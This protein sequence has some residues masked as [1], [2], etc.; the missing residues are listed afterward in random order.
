MKTAVFC[1][2]RGYNNPAL[3]SRLI[4]RNE[5]IYHF[6]KHES[7]DMV[8]FHEGNV[9]IEHQ[10]M[11]ESST[12]LTFKW[13]QIPWEFPRIPLPVET[14]STF[15]DGRCYPGYHLMCQFHTCDVWDY[16][17]DYDIV[18]RVDE[19]CILKSPKWEH[20]FKSMENTEYRT[21]MFDI[22]THELTNATLPLWLEDDSHYYDRTM[23]Y[24][25]IFISK[26]APWLRED[27]QD[28]LKKVRTSNGCIMYRWGDHVMQGIALKKFNI[29]SST[30][31]GFSYYHGSHD[32]HVD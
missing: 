18:L 19:D 3:Y 7:P 31:D 13:I 8:M 5:S 1:L 20:V 22:E 14:V 12:P 6:L 25:N 9:S 17:K 11:I 24:T 15:Y 29:S 27:V 30:L 26:I 28:W 21:P 16:L 23:P 10:K 2:T 4:S 32:R